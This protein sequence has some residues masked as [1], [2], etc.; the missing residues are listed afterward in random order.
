MGEVKKSKMK[1]AE[2]IT[3][4]AFNKPFD[5]EQLHKDD[6]FAVWEMVGKLNKMAKRYQEGNSIDDTERE[7]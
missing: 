5:F 3:Q 1:M 6:F 2:N 4:W 7:Y